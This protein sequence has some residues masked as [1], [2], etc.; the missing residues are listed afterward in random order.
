MLTLDIKTTARQIEQSIGDEIARR[1]FN[2]VYNPFTRLQAQVSNFIE[3]SIDS[4]PEADDLINGFLRT[5][6]GL[7]DP[8]KNVKSII[9]AI[10][11]AAQVK[12]AN[13]RYVG[14]PE[15]AGKISIEVLR[16]DL[17]EVLDLPDAS[18]TS[19]GKNSGEVE[20]LRWLL[21]GAESIVLPGFHI[22]HSP[23]HNQYSRT[24][25]DSL[26]FLGGNYSVT[27]S[28]FIQPQFSGVSGNNWLTRAMASM[29]AY[30]HPLV[31][32]EFQRA[33]S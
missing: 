11:Q 6:F 17:R 10:I 26:M 1:C 30:L 12:P 23:V 31:E 8:A 25:G 32:A 18:F 22:K 9:A 29:E 28:G 24:G 4:S 16:A 2:F 5:E 19:E 14:K 3:A 20:W 13:F 15:F 7:V 27:G 21:L 33:F